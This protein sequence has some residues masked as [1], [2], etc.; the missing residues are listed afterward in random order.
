MSGIQVIDVQ[1]ALE[2][3]ENDASLLQDVLNDLY[4][5]ADTMF[6]E[7]ERGLNNR[8]YNVVK[9]SSHKV[10]GSAANLYCEELRVTMAHLLERSDRAVRT[11]AT[12]EELN[13][14]RQLLN[15]GHSAV[16]KIKAVVRSTIRK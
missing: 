5:E 9:T 15:Q 8:D 1:T 3:F 6:A 10:K 12:N 4:Q 14:M 11:S 13:E 16:E 7:I 2:M